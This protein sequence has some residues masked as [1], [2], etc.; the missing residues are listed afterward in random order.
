MTRLVWDSPDERFYKTGID[1]GVFYVPDSQGEYNNG[2]AWNGL[3]SVDEDFGDDETE[4]HY[5]DG[6]KYLDSY[7]LGDFKATMTAF[8]YPDEFLPFEGVNEFNIG[9]YADDQPSK[10]FGLTYRTLTGSLIDGPDSSYQIHLLYN[11]TAVPSSLN[12]QNGSE[13]PQPVDFSWE[14]T[15]IPEI[16]WPYRPTAHIILDSELM[17]PEILEMLEDIIYGTDSTPPRLPSLADLVELVIG[18]NPKLIVHTPLTGLSP[19]VDGIGDLSETQPPGFYAAL[20]TTRLVATTP[21]GLYVL[22]EG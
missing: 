22:E 17:N 15:S 21:D 13:S 4:S 12:Y 2:F 5:Y 20:P 7:I 16:A 8:T 19:L 6:V 11:L 10:V 1:H 14:I 9:V 18:W 3:T